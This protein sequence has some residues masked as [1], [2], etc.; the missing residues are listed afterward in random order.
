MAA[1][2]AEARDRPATRKLKHPEARSPAP[3][4]TEQRHSQG[5]RSLRRCPARTPRAGARSG[6]ARRNPSAAVRTRTT[7]RSYD[8]AGFGHWTWPRCCGGLDSPAAPAAAEDT[9]ALGGAC[10]ETPAPG[11]TWKPTPATGGSPG[12]RRGGGGPGFQGCRPRSGWVGE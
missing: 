10:A 11:H 5:A 2:R 4:P 1:E 7:L 6:P 12:S 3:A 8:S 9:R